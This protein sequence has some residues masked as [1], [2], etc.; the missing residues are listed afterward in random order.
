MRI[1]P[2][3]VT[4]CGRATSPAGGGKCTLVGVGQAVVRQT[5]LK[6]CLTA[7]FATVDDGNLAPPAG[8]LAQGAPAPCD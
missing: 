4:A 7:N 3:S 5:F 1:S 2:L 6:L 8:E